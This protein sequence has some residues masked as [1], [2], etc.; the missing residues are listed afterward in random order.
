MTRITG[1]SD[2]LHGTE[3]LKEVSTRHPFGE[4]ARPIRRME[5]RRDENGPRIDLDAA[6]NVVLRL[7]GWEGESPN[8]RYILH[9]EFGHV[10]DRM[11]PVFQYS[12][13]ARL[14][15]NED[16]DKL[17]YVTDLWNTYIDGRLDRLGLFEFSRPPE[18][19][20]CFSLGKNITIDSVE[21]YIEAIACR[22]IRMGVPLEGLIELLKR[23]WSSP[24]GTLTYPFFFACYEKN[25]TGESR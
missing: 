23:V 3:L 12:L 22:Y 19:A 5:L 7:S 16:R 9:H 17:E 13:E 8:F 1:T 20:R 25:C 4:Y 14:C 21:S 2:V 11:D 10:Y 18:K 15:L 6:D 24:H